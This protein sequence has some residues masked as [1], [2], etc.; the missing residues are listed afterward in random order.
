[1]AK[2]KIL[3]DRAGK[4]QLQNNSIGIDILK[5]IKNREFVTSYV[6]IYGSRYGASYGSFAKP[7]NI[8]LGWIY[9]HNRWPEERSNA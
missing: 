2:N 8:C 5:K 3:S 4:G 7:L 1:M 6:A 9:K